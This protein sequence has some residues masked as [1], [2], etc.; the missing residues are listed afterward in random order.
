MIIQE[1]LLPAYAISGTVIEL[2]KKKRR[3]RKRKK[4]I[5][6]YSVTEENLEINEIV[7]IYLRYCLLV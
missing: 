2:R 1:N 7:S 4:K 3:R 6:E 5:K